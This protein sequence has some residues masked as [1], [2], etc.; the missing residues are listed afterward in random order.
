MNKT[1]RIKDI[2]K[3]SG[4]STGTVDRILHNR[5][6][7][8]PE[9]QAKVEKVLKEINYQPNLI[10]RSLALKK[11]YHLLIIIPQYAEGEYWA[12]IAEGVN[13]AQEELFSYNI[14]VEHLYFNQYDKSSFDALIPKIKQIDCQ[15]VV[16]STLFQEGVKDLTV[17]LDDLKI[18]YVLIDAYIEGTNA[19]T[20]YGT[21]SYDSGYIAGRL[22]LEQI[23]PQEDIVV[24]RFIRK[25][26]QASTQVT[27]REDGFRNYLSQNGYQGKI[28]LLH[29][30]G[31]ETDY[32]KEHLRS[33]FTENKQLKTGIIFNSRASMLGEYFDELNITKEFKL[34]G[35]DVLEANI[36]YLNSGLITHLIAQR[37]EV[38][39]LNSVKALFRYLILNVKDEAVNYMPI[40]ILI[41]ENISYYNNYI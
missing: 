7:V 38:Q 10:A 11:N 39:G 17:C 26:D 4:V 21:H 35:Y 41:K 5:G 2:A 9:A 6:K 22:L 36:H 20:Y 19:I 24:F 40:D 37:P 29:I 31:E 15:G 18:P 12:K 1:Y 13:K 27:K 8:S 3:L 30:H 16:V 33:F 34:I 14:T 23:N 28:H 32:N 25:G